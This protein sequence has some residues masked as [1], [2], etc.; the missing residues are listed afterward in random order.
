MLWFFDSVSRPMSR[1]CDI[2]HFAFPLGGRGRRLTLVISELLSMP[3]CSPV[4]ASAWILLPPAAKLGAGVAR[5]TFTVWDLHPPPYADFNRRF[6]T[7]PE[8][9]ERYFL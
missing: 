3:V 6:P 9:N 8:Y 7:V 2:S 4:Y 5:Y 1:V